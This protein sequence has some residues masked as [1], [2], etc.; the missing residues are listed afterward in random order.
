MEVFKAFAVLFG[1]CV[2]RDAMLAFHGLPSE[3]SLNSERRS[4]AARGDDLSG[5]CLKR[6]SALPGRTP[7]AGW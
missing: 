4:N 1:G 2:I 7:D 6:S 3:N 5:R